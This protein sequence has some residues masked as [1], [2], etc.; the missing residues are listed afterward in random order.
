MAEVDCRNRFPGKGQAGAR[1]ET[2]RGQAG[3]TQGSRAGRGGGW[4]EA[5][6]QKTD[7]NIDVF[8]QNVPKS[9]GEIE[10]RA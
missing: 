3:G 6:S 5:G 9:E 4:E 7:D 2:S 8:G 10:L 1:Q